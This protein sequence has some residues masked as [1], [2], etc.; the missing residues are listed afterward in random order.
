M[1]A[2][3]LGKKTGKEKNKRKAFSM[4]NSTRV[5][6]TLGCTLFSQQVLKNAFLP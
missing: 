3:T 2:A 6:K 1:S 4:N 5:F